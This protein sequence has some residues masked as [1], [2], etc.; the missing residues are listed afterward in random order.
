MTVQ[1][2]V[3]TESDIAAIER[4]GFSAFLP[5]ASPFEVIQAT[6]AQYP[7]RPAIR[8]HADPLQHSIGRD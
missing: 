1:K 7:D 2:T 3:R 5:H 8:R 4:Q 6:A